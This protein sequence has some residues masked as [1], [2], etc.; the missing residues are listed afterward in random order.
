MSPRRRMTAT[1]GIAPGALASLLLILFA[2]PA[3]ASPHQSRESIHQ[4]VEEFVLDH[5]RQLDRGKVEI[6]IRPIDPRLN[7]AACT[8]PLET[9]SVSAFRAVGGNH[10]GVRCD[11]PSPW[12]IHIPVNISIFE[13]IV[14]SATALPRGAVVRESDTLIERRE[15]GGLTGGYI[16]DP[17]EV[18]GKEIHRPLPLGAAFSRNSISNRKLVQRG[19]QVT[20][21][22][23]SAALN[24]TATGKALM[25]G[26]IGDVI[27]VANISSQR[28]VE[29]TI[30]AA[31]T[32]EVRP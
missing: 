20:L 17:G 7:L 16:T 2:L 9:F 15:V 22:I 32:V 1:T 23:S 11:A 30:T 26:G 13:N 8:N 4:A 29:G 10:I 24:V 12:K 31:G 6:E 27:K 28:V 5:T 19:Q 21:V 3:A 18:V 25:Q 14:V